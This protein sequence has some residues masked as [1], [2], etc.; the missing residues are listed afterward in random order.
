MF[1]KKISDKERKEQLKEEKRLKKNQRK[2][3]R[4]GNGKRI[5]AV[6]AVLLPLILT[7]I[8]VCLIYIFMKNKAI[9]E[10]I[11]SPVL[12]AGTDIPAN[13]FVKPEEAG[14]YFKQ[15]MVNADI[16]SDFTFHQ[17]SELPEDGFYVEN[18]LKMKQ[19][20]LMDDIATND[21]IMDKYG[22]DREETSFSIEYA[23]Q[24][25]N[26]R[27]RKGDIVDVYALDPETDQ[28]LCMVKDVYIVEVFDGA[29]NPL[30][31]TDGVAVGF[32]VL[33]SPDEIESLNKAI[34][35]GGIRLYLQNE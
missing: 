3:Q 31:A 11:K 25:L 20:L 8:I 7:I 19:M 15:I 28:M 24:G 27:L 23:S 34:A 26:G 22:E 5:T 4:K 33:V 18:A 13:T 12:I 35:C 9:T 29:S 30:K 10:E 6:K 21:E 16:V 32:N 14:N 17:I 1:E 2:E